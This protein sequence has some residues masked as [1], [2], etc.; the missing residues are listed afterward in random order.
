[1]KAFL[2]FLGLLN[3]DVS[4]FGSNTGG[5]LRS[6]VV[7]PRNFI[8]DQR[9]F[10]MNAQRSIHSF[11]QFLEEDQERE[12][13]NTLLQLKQQWAIAQRQ[14]QE[15]KEINHELKPLDWNGKKQELTVTIENLRTMLKYAEGNYRY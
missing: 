11:E 12:G 6:E 14:L 8:E 7:S 4:E 3:L 10:L 1:M 13:E 15:L 2:I 5:A 9:N